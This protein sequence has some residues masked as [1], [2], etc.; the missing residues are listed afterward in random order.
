MSHQPTHAEL[1]LHK[2][3]RIRMNGLWYIKS[4]QTKPI[5]VGIAPNLTDAANCF[6]DAINKGQK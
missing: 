4:V 6:M 2:T 3:T 5:C 1:A